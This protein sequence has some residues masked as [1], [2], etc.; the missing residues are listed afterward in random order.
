MPSSA[1]PPSASAQPRTTVPAASVEREAL[2]R[3]EGDHRLRLSGR[4][5][6]PGGADGGC[7]RRSE[8]DGQRV[9]MGQLAGVGER[10]AVPRPG[11]LRIA[12]D[13]EHV[14]EPGQA[15]HA[16][17]DGVDEGRGRG[18]ARGR[19]GRAPPQSGRGSRPTSRAGTRPTRRCGGRSPARRR[20]PAPRPSAAA[21]AR[22]RAPRPARH[23]GSGT[24]D[25][26]YRAGKSSGTSPSS[27]HSSRAR[28]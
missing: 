28:A 2:L 6:G 8:G 12:E 14:G 13:D 4:L 24:T 5:A 16:R 23:A 27:R 25:R 10:L 17:V 21:P 18:P 22:P 9:G 1:R 11:L 7:K 20:R 3:R 26:P 15:H 19:R